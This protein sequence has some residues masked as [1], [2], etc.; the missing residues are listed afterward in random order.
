MKDR[1]SRLAITHTRSP[2]PVYFSAQARLT[3]S[4]MVETFAQA[5]KIF[6]YSKNNR[7]ER[8]DVRS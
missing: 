2:I 7:R 6:C 3:G 4:R 8:P 5:A 1:Q